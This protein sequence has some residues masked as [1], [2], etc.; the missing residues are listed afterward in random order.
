MTDSIE[1]TPDS[2]VDV[3]EIEDYAGD[4]STELAVAEDY[5]PAVPTAARAVVYYAGIA[6]IAVSFIWPDVDLLTRIGLAVGFVASTLGVSF[7]TR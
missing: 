6:S 2:T 3:P 5:K 4:E 1:T 7:R